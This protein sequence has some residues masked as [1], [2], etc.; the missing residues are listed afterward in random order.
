MKHRG[1][2]FKYQKQLSKRLFDTRLLLLSLSK[3]LA[4]VRRLTLTII[5]A[6][7]IRWSQ[8]GC[9]KGASLTTSGRSSWIAP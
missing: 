4:D 3:R 1:K 8:A 9:W 2:Y 6:F 5:G 7:L